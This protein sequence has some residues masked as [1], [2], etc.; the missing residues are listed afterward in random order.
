M[1]TP[2]SNGPWQLYRVAANPAN[3]SIWHQISSA[4]GIHVARR[5]HGTYRV[6]IV[7]SYLPW[8]SAHNIEYQLDQHPWKPLD[9][10]ISV[11][12]EW[13]AHQNAV[14][15]WLQDAFTAISSGKSSGLDSCYRQIARSLHRIVLEWA[16]LKRDLVVTILSTHKEWC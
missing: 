11:Y 13:A 12:G 5:H 4:P 2:L 10:E 15:H 16:I 14:A 7:D 3:S 8:F 6:A 1:R 9:A